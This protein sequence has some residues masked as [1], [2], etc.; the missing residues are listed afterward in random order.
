MFVFCVQMPVHS[1]YYCKVKSVCDRLAVLASHCHENDFKQRFNVLSAL[2]KSWTESDEYQLTAVLPLS[3][4]SVAQPDDAEI[5]HENMS[6]QYEVDTVTCDGLAGD[7]TAKQACS[8]CT[9]SIIGMN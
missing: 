5:S 7:E 1:E 3:S 6:Q 2:C 4:A 8:D 9:Q